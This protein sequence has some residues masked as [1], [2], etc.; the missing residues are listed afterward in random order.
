MPQLCSLKV[1]GPNMIHHRLFFLL[2]GPFMSDFS[3]LGPSKKAP[4]TMGIN[5]NFVILVMEE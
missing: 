5:E 4:V 2:K 3:H 1:A